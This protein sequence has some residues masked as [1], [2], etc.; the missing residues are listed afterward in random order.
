MKIT[1]IENF[2]VR[3]LGRA[4]WLFCAIRTDEGITGYSEYGTGAVLARAA[5]TRRGS[6]GVADRSGSAAGGQA[7]HGYVPAH[8][9]GFGRGDGD[10]DSGNRA[11]AVGHQGEGARGTCSQAGGRAVQGQAAG[12]LVAPGD[13]PGANGGGVGEAEAGDD[14]RTWRIARGRRW[15]RGIRRSRRT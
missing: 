13:V 8:A 3:G 9:L 1:G 5:G 6:G 12:V 4:P 7:V 11:G 2:A 10:G 14:G 15:T